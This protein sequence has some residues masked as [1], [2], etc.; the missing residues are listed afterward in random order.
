MRSGNWM[1][2]V[3]AGDR[4]VCVMTAD[5]PVFPVEWNVVLSTE[6]GNIRW[7]PFFFFPNR[8]SKG[9][10]MTFVP[11]HSIWSDSRMSDVAWTIS[12]IVRGGLHYQNIIL[13]IKFVG[14]NWNHRSRCAHSA[15]QGRRRGKVLAQLS[16]LTLPVWVEEEES[17]R[18]IGWWER[19]ENIQKHVMSWSF[20]KE[21]VAVSL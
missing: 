7:R 14:G 13:T 8:G 18:M 12:L 21:A 11:N 10:N 19:T 1:D 20:R 17:A 15:S 5:F 4:E 6:I 16:D 3:E 2:A 9:Q